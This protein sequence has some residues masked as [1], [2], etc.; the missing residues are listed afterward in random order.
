MWWLVYKDRWVRL[1][2]S[3]E[4][5]GVAFVLGV[6]FLVL[7]VFVG[8]NPQPFLKFGYT[9]VFVFN[10]FGGA[11]VLLIPTLS[12]YMNLPALA[13][14]SALGMAFNDSVSWWVG[15]IGHTIIPHSKKLERIEGSLRRSGWPVLFLWSLIPFPYDLI[16]F[17]AG[18]LRFS[19]KSFL[20]P[21]FLG[22]FVRFLL[23][24]YGAIKLFG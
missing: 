1:L 4:I 3:R 14:V 22:K 20:V 8:V 18:Y 5:K 10:M 7:A 17:V 24:G 16:G 9:G 13:F 15:G 2:G 11:G 19:Y 21:T 6:V 23:I 12:R